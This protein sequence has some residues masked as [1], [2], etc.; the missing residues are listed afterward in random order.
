VWKVDVSECPP[1]HPDLAGTLQDIQ[2]KLSDPQFVKAICIHEAAHAV[3]WAQLGRDTTP[4]YTV[5]VRR[6]PD[7]GCV[8]EYAAVVLVN[9]AEQREWTALGVAKA[10]AAGGAVTE[11]L[12]PGYDRGDSEDFNCFQKDI[13]AVTLATLDDLEK[14][15]ETARQEIIAE[16][17]NP[18]SDI[19]VNIDMRAIEFERGFRLVSEIGPDESDSVG[20][21]P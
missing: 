15:W 14:V 1:N 3:Y 11:I 13:L 21:E 10:H 2:D 20:L 16:L 6:H 7:A 19:Q 12:V 9:P 17:Q 8:I 5:R 4:D 18:A